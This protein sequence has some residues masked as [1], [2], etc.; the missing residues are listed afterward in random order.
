MLDQGHRSGG[1]GREV[2]PCSLHKWRWLAID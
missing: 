1:S 2:L